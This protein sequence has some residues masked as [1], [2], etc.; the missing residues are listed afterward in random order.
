MLN[1]VILKF[2]FG[3]VVL[4][5]G[6]YDFWFKI[7]VGVLLLVEKLFDVLGVV[8]VFFGYDFVIVIKDDIDW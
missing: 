1:L 5:E 3:W 6:M 7:D 2:F 8:V 4:F